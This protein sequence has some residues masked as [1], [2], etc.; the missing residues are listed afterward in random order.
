MNKYFICSWY[1]GREDIAEILGLFKIENDRPTQT[2]IFPDKD[3]VTILDTDNGIYWVWIFHSDHPE[4]L[5]DYY[6]LF[7]TSSLKDKYILEFP[8]DYTAMLWF[9]LNYGGK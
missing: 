6:N 1:E 3:Y 4:S 9:K 2:L 8:D 7:A 5:L